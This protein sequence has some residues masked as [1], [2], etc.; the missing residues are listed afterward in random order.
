MN[1][2]ASEKLVIVFRSRLRPEADLAALEAAG[3]RMYELASAMPGF[4]S[5][6][7]FTAADGES[8]ALVEFA[9][10]ASLLAWRDHPEHQAMQQ[11]GRDEFFAEYAI[12]VCR[13]VRAYAFRR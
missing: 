10:M 5:Y 9:D 8:L 6:Q 1:A 11:R 4:I 3:A 12:E 2:P 7:D 13:T